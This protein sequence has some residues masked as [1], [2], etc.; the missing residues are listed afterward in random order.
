MRYSVNGVDQGECFRV[1]TSSLN[2]QALFPHV[3]VKN[4]EFS[5]NFG[6]EGQPRFAPNIPGGKSFG[7]FDSNS[8]LMHRIRD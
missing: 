5:V 6:Q 8:S 7:I 3:Y 1:L 2:S 4:V